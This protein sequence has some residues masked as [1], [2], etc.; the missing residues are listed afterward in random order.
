MRA[1]VAVVAVVTLRTSV[2]AQNV[3]RDSAAAYTAFVAGKAAVNARNVDIAVEQLER[4]VALDPTQW[5]YHMWLGHAYTHQ[6]GRVN[7]MRKAVVGRRMGAEYNKAVELAPRS[8]EAAE[9]RLDF[10]INAPSIVGGGQDKANAEAARIATLDPYRGGLASARVGEHAK[11]FA[12]AE[13]AY[14]QLMRQYPDSGAPV[15]WLASLMEA[16]GRYDE[17]FAVVDAR[18]GKFPDDAT[19]LY[20]LGRLSSSSG[21]ELQRG[22]QALRRFLALVGV[23]DPFRQASGHYRLGVIREK[24]GDSTAAIAEY[25][26]AVELNPAHQSAS[27]AL[28]KLE[29]RR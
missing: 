5:E 23:Q 29:H 9:A 25:R 26:R 27:E 20:Q 21:R 16:T 8:V 2:A 24:L 7:F 10:F 28:K 13:A 4:A 15:A 17:A 14:R 18:L 6:I 11:D 12:R 3:P 22:E 19:N 1:I